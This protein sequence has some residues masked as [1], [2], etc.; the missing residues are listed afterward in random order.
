MASID[1]LETA[2]LILAATNLPA[3]VPRP[4][5]RLDGELPPCAL[6]GW[7]DPTAFK[8]SVVCV[9]CR[10]QILNAVTPSVPSP[11]VPSPPAHDELGQFLTVPASTRARA[12][13]PARRG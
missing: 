5:Y 12:Q 2:W 4:E 13:Q 1:L 3:Q 10:T 7:P 9:R 8:G 6:C 11:P